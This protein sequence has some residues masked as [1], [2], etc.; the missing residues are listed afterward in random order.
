MEEINTL[1]WTHWSLHNGRTLAHLQLHKFSGE[2]IDDFK[3]A[4]ESDKERE[5]CDATEFVVRSRKIVCRRCA[6]T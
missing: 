2:K 3:I 6:S 1:T 4:T 5:R